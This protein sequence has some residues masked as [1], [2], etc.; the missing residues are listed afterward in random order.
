MATGKLTDIE[1]KKAKPGEKPVKL[2][3]GGGMYLLIRPDGSKYWR[4][5]Y[6]HNN[7]RK[8]LALGVYPDVSL[9]DARDRCNAARKQ[10]ANDTDPGAI[11]KAAKLAGIEAAANTFESIALRWHVET[12]QAGKWSP[13]HAARIWHAL[14]KDVFPFMGKQP[15][16][17][18]SA[19]ECKKTI[20]RIAD[21]GAVESAH[22]T[23]QNVSLIF[24]YAVSHAIAP[25]NPMADLLL[26]LPTVQKKH[27]ATITDPKRVGQLMRD[28]DG[29]RGSFVTRCALKLAA[30]VFVRPGELR[31]AE[32]EHFDLDAGTWRYFVTKTK[33]QH[34]V[35]L[36]RQAIAILHELHLL[37]GQGRLVFPGVRH[38]DRPMSENTKNQ[39]LKSLGYT[40]EDIVP[41]GFRG[42]A[43]SLLNEQ[44]WNP[45]AI[46]R[47]LAHK[48]QN[49][50]RGSYN[51]AEY[52]GERRE[53]MQAWADYL[54]RLCVGADVIDLPKRKRS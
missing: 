11:K 47:Q 20:K 40:S 46:E 1:V 15:I 14:E 12:K 6:R 24:K 45:D 10:L 9:K 37:T 34:I 22:R 13:D 53:M 19:P 33:T 32:W 42:M 27:F 39:A 29:Y 17:G 30:L 50:V 43:S 8:T 25:R 51:H 31:R 18:I 48:E 2:S 3:D 36:S 21:R 5:D 16:T 41:H 44:G 28:I 54:E 49:E 7:K 4:L 38:H 35:P 52:M 23:A 26:G